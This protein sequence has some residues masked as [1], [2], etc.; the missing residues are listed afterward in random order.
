MDGH[1]KPRQQAK[2]VVH[3]AAVVVAAALDPAAVLPTLPVVAVEAPTLR[4]LRATAGR[5]IPVIVA[6]AATIMIKER[7]VD[8]RGAAVVG[9]PDHPAAA[10]ARAEAAADPR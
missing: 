6:A 8:D 1:A 9:D 2:S 10:A 3:E 4:R 7:V 5:H